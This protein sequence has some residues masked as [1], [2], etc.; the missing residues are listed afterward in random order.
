M[1]T[2]VKKKD[3]ELSLGQLIALIPKMYRWLPLCIWFSHSD[4]IIFFCKPNS[5][6]IKTH[7]TLSLS[8]KL[9]PGKN[10]DTLAKAWATIYADRLKKLPDYNLESYLVLYN[11]DIMINHSESCD[12]WLK[13]TP[14]K[15]NIKKTT[16]INSQ[17]QSLSIN[18]ND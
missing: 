11:K 7:M 10:I 18:V 5:T 8:V 14:K 6:F 12:F 17:I 2:S 16:I 3:K 4:T 15:F 13:N 1:K 9:Q